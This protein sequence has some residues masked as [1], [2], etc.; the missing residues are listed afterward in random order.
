VTVLVQ[1]IGTVK[2]LSVPDAMALVRRSNMATYRIKATVS[3]GT[4]YFNY[5][6]SLIAPTQSAIETF[7]RGKVGERAQ[8]EKIEN[9]G[10]LNEDKEH[11]YGK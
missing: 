10:R 3:G 2:K 8:I 11:P 6:G 1:S 5:S 9:L 7:V 4:M